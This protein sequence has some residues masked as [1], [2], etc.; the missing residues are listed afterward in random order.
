[1]ALFNAFKGGTYGTSRNS[2]KII[3]KWK[4]KISDERKRAVETRCTDYMDLL[5]YRL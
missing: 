4:L 5:N 2:E 3:D 1:M